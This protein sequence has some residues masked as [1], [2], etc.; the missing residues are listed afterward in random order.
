MKIVNHSNL[1]LAAE[2]M[3]IKRLIKEYS[4]N[5]KLIR[6]T[7]HEEIQENFRQNPLPHI[8]QIYYTKANQIRISIE[9]KEDDN[10]IRLQGDYSFNYKNEVMMR[11]IKK[12][13]E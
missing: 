4:M 9:E 12:W 5:I 2:A 10:N 3:A 13:L 8:V 6:I 11:S 1:V 7:V